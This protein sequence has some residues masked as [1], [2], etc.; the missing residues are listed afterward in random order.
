[1]EPDPEMF[2][3]CREVTTT[4]IS[5]QVECH[6]RFSEFRE[7]QACRTCHLSFEEYW[8]AYSV[9]SINLRQGT[10]SSVE[11]L[12]DSLL[13]DMITWIDTIK[14]SVGEV[15]IS[16]VKF[17]FNR[18]TPLDRLDRILKTIAQELPSYIIL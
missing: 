10:Y 17:H 6:H 8:G 14:E 11:S 12:V 9:H 7:D 2:N 16:K 15:S 18:G 5:S 13:L 1:M 3:R 4:V